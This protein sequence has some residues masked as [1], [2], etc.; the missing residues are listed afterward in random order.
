MRDFA[1]WDVLQEE[2]KRQLEVH[3]DRDL[4]RPLPKENRGSWFCPVVDPVDARLFERELEFR[5]IRKVYDFGAGDCRLSYWLSEKGYEVIAY[6]TQRD[7]PT[8]AAKRLG[9]WPFELRFRD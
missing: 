7:M 2:W 6:E 1:I 9:P 4:A 3:G 8:W 5:G